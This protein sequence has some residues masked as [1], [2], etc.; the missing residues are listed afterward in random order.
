MKTG[1]RIAVTVLVLLFV[2]TLFAAYFGWGMS[3]AERATAQSVRAGS[4]RTR[5][6]FGGGTGSWGS[7]GFGK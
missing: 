5:T 2:L 1:Y 6:H 7:G 3:A 4:M